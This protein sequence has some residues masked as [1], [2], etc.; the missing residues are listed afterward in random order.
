M[1]VY[2]RFW[3]SVL[4]NTMRIINIYLTLLLILHPI[5]GL[6]L[7]LTLLDFLYYNQIKTW[8]EAQIFC[9]EEHTDLITI[10]NEEE[11]Q[12]FSGWKAWIGLYRD[13]VNIPWKWSRGDKTAS[14]LTWADKGKRQFKLWV[15]LLFVNKPFLFFI[16]IYTQKNIGQEM[17]LKRYNSLVSPAVPYRG[18][19]MYPVSWYNFVPF[20]L[21]LRSGFSVPVVTIMYLSHTTNKEQ[22]CTQNVTIDVSSAVP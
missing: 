12:V 10:R 5:S 6:Y 4:I 1:F 9:R 19:I 21:Y 3:N 15:K 11:N 13:N 22:K 16:C 20:Y 8:Q 7:N 17:Y 14:F 18:T 2:C